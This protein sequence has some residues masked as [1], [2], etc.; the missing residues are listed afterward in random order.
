MTM[1]DLVVVMGEGR[2]HQAATP[3]EIYRNPADAFVADFIGSTNLLPLTRAA[4]GSALL[5][6]HRVDGLAMPA[7]LA[8]GV[9]SVR[10]EDVRLQAPGSGTLDARITFVRDLGATV[11]TFLSANDTT[12]ISVASPRERGPFA[13]GHTVGV[14]LSAPQCLVFAHERAWPL[15]ALITERVAR[16]AIQ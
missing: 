6:G 10:P 2:V 3:I 9:L 15:Q 4:D 11:E 16:R 8:A 14:A 12:F 1:A 5:W 13:V 7:G